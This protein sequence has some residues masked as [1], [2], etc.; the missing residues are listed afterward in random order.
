MLYLPAGTAR[1]QRLHGGYV[2][3]TEIHKIVEFVKRQGAP[4]YDLGLLESDEEEGGEGFEDDLS[5]DMYDQ[6][7][8]IVTQSRIASISYLQRRLRVGY[9]RAARMIERMEREGVVSP[10]SG[11]KPREV[12]AQA[13]A[14]D[15]DEEE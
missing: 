2:S 6:G 8:R 14:G 3:E 5:D 4:A 13:I 7:V 12:L 11:S 15:E 1:A 10:G 9:N